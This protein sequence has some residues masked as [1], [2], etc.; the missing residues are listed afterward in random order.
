M[1][2]IIGYI[3]AGGHGMRMKPFRLIKEL[4]PVYVTEE[5]RNDVI[6]LIENAIQVLEKGGIKNVVCTVNQEKDILVQTISDCCDDETEKM[7]FAFV[8]QNNLNKEYGLPYAIMKSA[9]F[10]KGNV[11]FMKFPDTLVYPRDCFKTLYQFHLEKKA[12]LTLGVFPTENPQRLGPVIMDEHGKVLR[13]EDKPQCPSVR[14]TWNVLIW[15]DRFLDL[16]V[17]YVE[18]YRSQIGDKKELLLYD[19]FLLA[20]EEGLKV[21]AHEFKDGSCYDI[22]CIEDAK[23]IWRGDI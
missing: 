15:E 21:Y 8:Y 23:K 10:M 19:I 18:K 20:L 3:P 2:K 4:M 5:N 13:I 17:E 9:P 12:D 11:V 6:L 14:N 16:V 7:T 1:K 22:S